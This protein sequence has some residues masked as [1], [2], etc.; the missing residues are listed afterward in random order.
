MMDPRNLHLVV[1]NLVSNAV[2]YTA[3]GQVTVRAGAENG[4]AVL[5]VSDTGMGIPAADVPKLFG[6]FFRAANAKA[7]D[8]EGSGV[9]LASVK[10]LVER[11]G[12]RIDVQ[13]REGE[14]TTLTVR[15]PAR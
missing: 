4:M 8:I 13:T 12:G 2:K 10:C 5:G 11:H 14:G 9:G 6:E 1:S 7:S 15:L 3:D